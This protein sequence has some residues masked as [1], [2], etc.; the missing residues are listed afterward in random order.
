MKGQ[1]CDG[2]TAA[3]SRRPLP[4]VLPCQR[5]SG[6]GLRAPV[7][8]CGCCLGW[9]VVSSGH[10]FAAGRI[11]S[12]Y[13]VSE[14]VEE[15]MRGIETLEGMRKLA[16]EVDNNWEDVQAKLE[17]IR[18]LLIDRRN[19]IVNLSAEDG[20][21][22]GA[23]QAN[24][25][26]YIAKMPLRTEDVKIQDWE[27]EMK[28]MSLAHAGEGFIVP[29][30]VNYVGKGAMLYE[31]GETTSGA[32]A[33]V[34]R[35][36]RTSWLWDKIRVVGGAYGAMNSYNPATGM[37]KYV[38]YRDPNLMSTLKTYDET[39]NFLRELSKEMTPTTLANSII[40]MIG[41]MDAP[42]APDQK[43]FT[44]MDRWLTG[45][46][47]EMRQERREQVLGTTAKDF[48]EFGEKLE[49][50]RNKGSIAVIGSAAEL[51]DPAVK[52]LGLDVQK[53]L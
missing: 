8:T 10:S 45:N 35:H 16:E 25:E 18:D 48:A 53:L 36:L 43:G 41:D 19:L 1:L 30:Q 7:V 22:F 49:I 33:V 44:S 23:V 32:A 3:A 2:G 14:F 13:L 28:K 34:S 52:A 24:L 11:G 20:K 51:D 39:P 37:F 29:T 47:D 12:R 27:A 50:V 4:L 15:K 6:L 17:R 46:T 42:M 38:S 31:V 26:E 40:G 9:Q 21:G 5:T